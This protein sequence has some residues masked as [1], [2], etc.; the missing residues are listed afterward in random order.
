[1]G[2]ALVMVAVLGLYVVLAGDRAVRLIASGEPA[3]IGA[4]IALVVF[5]LLGVWVLVREL[6][7]GVRLDRA[8]REL[9]A[10]G[11]M[12]EPLPATPSG[13]AELEAANAAFP[14]AR[15]DVEA[16]PESWQSWLRL[17]M[18]YDA[19]RDRKRAREAARTALRL[20]KTGGREAP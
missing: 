4:G 8:V 9:D 12:P 18:A 7:F 14:A 3:G 11:G 13:R 17:S 20:R 5:F 19:A 1:M 15:A 6:V 2:F 10:Q 16:H